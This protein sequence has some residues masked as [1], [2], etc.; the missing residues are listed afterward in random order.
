MNAGLKI[1]CDGIDR[2]AFRQIRAL[3]ECGAYGD[4]G[5]RIMPDAHAGVGCTIGTTMTLTDR[6]TPNL[7][8]VDIGCGMVVAELGRVSVDP[9]LLEETIG[10][11]VPSGMNVR[12]RGIPE[13]DEAY[14]LLDELRC[15]SGRTSRRS[16]LSPRSVPR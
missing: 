15:P 16:L 10:R 3:V 12:E 5:I 11:D 6:V 1:F 4:S 14:A 9:F 8:G 13:T 2:T 7:V